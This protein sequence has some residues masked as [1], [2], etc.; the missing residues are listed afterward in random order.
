MKTKKPKLLAKIAAA[1]FAGMLAFALTACKTDADSTTKYTVTYEFHDT[2]TSAGTTTIDGTDYDLVYFGDWPQTIKAESVLIDE[3]NSKSVGLYTYY[4]GSDGNWYAKFLENAC[5]GL[6]YSDG[7]EPG[8]GHLARERYFKVEPIKWRVLNPNENGNK[9]LFA[10]S[11]LTANVVYYDYDWAHGVINRTIEG[12]TIYP[13]NYKHSKIRAYL[14]GLSYE[15]KATDSDEQTT[16]TTYNENGFLQT[17]FTQS[18]QA[19]IATTTVD[20][21]EESTN[22]ASNSKAF[23]SGKNENI[24]EN[25]EDKIF[26][27]SEKEATTS[28]YGFTEYN[29]YGEGNS[30]TRSSTDFAKANRAYDNPNCNWMLRSP[31]LGSSGRSELYIISGAYGQASTDSYSYGVRVIK[32][33]RDYVW[34]DNYSIVPALCVSAENLPQ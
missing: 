31:C 3:S 24:C 1:V 16:D 29:V 33:I 14:N 34:D 13:N 20:N 12:S 18:A 23:N 25:T 9:I 22:P 7:T 8:H 10:E 30:R 11:V 27:L 19:L 5:Y 26:L 2:V 6:I 28:D 32:G 21:S 15:V 4:A 17:A